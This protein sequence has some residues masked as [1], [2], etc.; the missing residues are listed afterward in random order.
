MES[1]CYVIVVV[2]VGAMEEEEEA[3]I[4]AEEAE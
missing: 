1:C 2:D 4:N 3:E